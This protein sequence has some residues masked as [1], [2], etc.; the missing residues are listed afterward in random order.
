[1]KQKVAII[2]GA[3]HGIGRGIA[4]AMLAA[5]YGLVIGEKNPA[6]V[7]EARPWFSGQKVSILQMDVSRER[8]VRRLAARGPARSLRGVQ[9]LGFALTGFG[10]RY[11]KPT[12]TPRTSA[13]SFFFA[14]IV[15]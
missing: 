1:M 4:E 2:T 11:L 10:M 14:T 3:G 6:R 8:D 13:R 7:R 12:S 15:S 9:G 5:G